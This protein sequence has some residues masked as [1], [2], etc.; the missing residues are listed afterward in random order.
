MEK[1]RYAIKAQCASCDLDI[2]KNTIVLTCN[3]MLINMLD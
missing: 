1:L 3:N 2:E